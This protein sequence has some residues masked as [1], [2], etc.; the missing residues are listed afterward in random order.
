MSTWPFGPHEPLASG[1]S[2]IQGLFSPVEFDHGIQ[3]DGE[4]SGILNIAEP[5]T[6]ESI[7]S[8]PITE[9]YESRDTA[10]TQ[11]TNNVVRY[12]YWLV[13]FLD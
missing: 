4:M 5:F 3:A 2:S 8:N 10:E 13:P 6:L 9:V 11:N 7:S 12:I 1:D